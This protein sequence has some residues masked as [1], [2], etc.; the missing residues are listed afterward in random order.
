MAHT[1]WNLGY[2]DQASKLMAEAESRTHAL[3]NP[4]AE[5]SVAD[6]YATLHMIG[7]DAPRAKAYADT[8]VRIANEFGFATELISSNIARGWA[9]A[10][11]GDPAG[12]ELLR[13]SMRA[14]WTI[15]NNMN[16][17][18][19]CAWLAELYLRFGRNEEADEA[20]DEG[21]EFGSRTNQGLAESDLYRLKGE[22]DL[23]LDRSNSSAARWFERAID[24]AR[25]RSAKIAELRATICLAQLLA[26]QGKR[27]KAR[28]ML[29]E[30]Y[31]WFTEGFDTADLKE[32]KALLDEL[33]Q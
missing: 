12:I 4:F 18:Q 27:K 20:L 2:Q 10:W 3:R 16:R 23:R 19:E 1:M 5:V 14:W 22:T 31:G 7:R 25:K 13:E 30:I 33:S 11:L 9:D 8:M 28:A 26:K 24:V 6:L 32:A 29:T 15:G 17:S 21:L